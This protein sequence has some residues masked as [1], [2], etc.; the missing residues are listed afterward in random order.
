MSECPICNR[1]TIG[2]SEYCE[3]HAEAL[4]NIE[5]AYSIWDNAMNITWEDYLEQL[6]D[7]ENAGK[8][9]REVAEYL[10]QQDDS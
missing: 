6:T 4:M 3:Y 9:A 8:W 7:E 10:T 2:D 1:G 5:K